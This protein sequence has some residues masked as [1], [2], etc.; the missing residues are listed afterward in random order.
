MEIVFD[1][2]TF[3]YEAFRRDRKKSS[4][5]LQAMTAA[6]AAFALRD[7]SF[8]LSS[9]E[10]LAI[11]GRSGSGKSTLMNFFT[12]LLRPSRGKI[13]IDGQDIFSSAA[14]LSTIRRRLGLVFQFPESQL[15]E[16]SVYDD[17]AYAPRNLGL[18]ETVVEQRIEAALEA[19]GLPMRDFGKIDPMHLS[20]GEKRRAAIAG[21]L[22]MQPE[23]LI[24]DEPTAGLDAAG[25]ELLIEVLRDLRHRG[26]GLVIISHDTSLAVRFANRALVLSQGRLDYDGRLVDILRDERLASQWGLEIP[27]ERRLTNTLLRRELPISEIEG[28]LEQIE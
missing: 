7:I 24:L 3:V 19:V 21:V 10:C 1:R 12:G 5:P 28:I 13:T 22:A 23:M 20:Q 16:L 4:P 8:A 2:V 27:R 25:R 6:D 14:P 11:L 15:F 26:I 17:V 18:A 9:D